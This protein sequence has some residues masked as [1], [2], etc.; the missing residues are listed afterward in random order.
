M[1]STFKAYKHDIMLLCVPKMQNDSNA[2][3]V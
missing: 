2:I 1:S 3:D